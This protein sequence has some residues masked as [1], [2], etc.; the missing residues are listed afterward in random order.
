MRGSP[1]LEFSRRRVIQRVSRLTSAHRRVSTSRLRHGDVREAGN[2]IDRVDQVRGI[3]RKSAR[4]TKPRR[5]LCSASNLMNGAWTMRSCS[6]PSRWARLS[7]ASSRLMD[8]HRPFLLTLAGASCRAF[9]I[10]WV[11]PFLTE[12]RRGGDLDGGVDDATIW[13]A[14]ECGAGIARRA[15]EGDALDVTG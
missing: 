9:F 7:A 15:D 4:S 12:H 5:M 13:L 11:T 1:D 6:M 2:V 14:C 10:R 3:S 8:H